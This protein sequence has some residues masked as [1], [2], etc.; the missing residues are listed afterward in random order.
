MQ[1]I[2][3]T[4]LI[5]SL[6]S[7]PSKSFGADQEEFYLGGLLCL[8]GDCAEVGDNSRKGIELATE[9]INGSGGILGKKLALKFE[10]TKEMGGPGSVISAFQNLVLDPKIR[11]IIGPTWTVGGLPLA[12]ILAKKPEVIAISPSLGV[13]TYNEASDTVF[14]TWPHDDASTEALAKYAF[15]KG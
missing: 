8:T 6:T 5:L 11:Y 2:L 15:K 4:F 9:E 14:N 13:A 1:K 7:L 3:T 12:P 10:D